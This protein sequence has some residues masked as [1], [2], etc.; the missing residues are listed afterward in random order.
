MSYV[1]NLMLLIY[2][3]LP[4]VHRENAILT[5]KLLYLPENSTIVKC[6]IKLVRSSH[7]SFVVKTSFASFLSSICPFTKKVYTKHY[8]L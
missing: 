6:F 3:K 8:K 7:D 4:S 5:A 1:V 2:K